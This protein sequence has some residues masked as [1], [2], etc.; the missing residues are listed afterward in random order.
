MIDHAAAQ[1]Q[2]AVLLFPRLRTGEDVAKLV[3]SLADHPRWT[4]SR[5]PWRKHP[6][7]EDQQ[8]SLLWRTAAGTQSSAIGFAEDGWH[9]QK[10]TFCLPSISLGTH[11]ESVAAL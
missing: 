4:L 5:V 3:L 7:S 11:T 8:L 10:V 1:K 2:F 9:L 6:R